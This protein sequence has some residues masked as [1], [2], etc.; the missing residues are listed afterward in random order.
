MIRHP[1]GRM[2]LASGFLANP[3]Q[4]RVRHGLKPHSLNQPLAC[5][6]SEGQADE[7]KE[8]TKTRGVPSI[9][10]YDVGQP[11][12]EDLAYT[13][14]ILAEKAPHMQ[15]ESYRPARPR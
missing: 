6:P 7:R 14:F 10:S 15:F 3:P 8:I 4:E 5:F 9:G 2:H 11:L 1:P 13:F 12:S